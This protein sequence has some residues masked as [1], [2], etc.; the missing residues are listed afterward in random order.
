M[1]I[2]SVCSRCVAI[3]LGILGA[4]SFGRELHGGPL[5][6]MDNILQHLDVE[7]PV[8]PTESWY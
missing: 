7:P 5:F 8:G 1:L 3:F 4:F 2:G 6:L